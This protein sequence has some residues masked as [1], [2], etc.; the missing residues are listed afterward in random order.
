MKERSVISQVIDW[1]V[2]QVKLQIVGIH[3][4]VTKCRAFIHLSQANQVI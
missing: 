4:E 3:N 2:P 1:A